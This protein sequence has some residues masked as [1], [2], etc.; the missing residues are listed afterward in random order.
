MKLQ[1]F[2]ESLKK[3][4]KETSAMVP[5]IAPPE[6]N[7]EPESVPEIHAD[8]EMNTCTLE[9]ELFRQVLEHCGCNAEVADAIVQQCKLLGKSVGTLTADHFEDIVGASEYETPAA[10]PTI[11]SSPTVMSTPVVTTQQYT[12]SIKDETNEKFEVVDTAEDED[13]DE[14]E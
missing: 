12:E 9:C 7:L 11:G 6:G 8:E 13:E 10:S 14:D 1:E 2:A 3:A 5:A 4:F